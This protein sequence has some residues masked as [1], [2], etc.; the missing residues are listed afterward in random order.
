MEQENG[1]KEVEDKSKKY[2]VI[3]FPGARGKDSADA[4]V[5]PVNVAGKQFKFKRNTPVPVPYMVLEV[6]DHAQ[7]PVYF[8]VEG[9]D[10]KQVEWRHRYPYSVLAEIS[11]AGYKKLRK[12]AME[13]EITKEEID[14]ARI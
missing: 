14:K 11:Y 7:Y 4:P 10:R 9:E 5:V 13:R 8:T 6:L 1:M 12:I 2:F 3:Q